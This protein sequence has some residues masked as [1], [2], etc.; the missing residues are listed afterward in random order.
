LAA[1]ENVQS[2]DS[3]GEQSRTRD[4]ARGVIQVQ[5]KQAREIH[6]RFM[7]LKEG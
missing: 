6:N 3:P 7:I 5:V 2:C 4:Q 1:A